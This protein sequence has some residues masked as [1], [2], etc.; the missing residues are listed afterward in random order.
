MAISG[1]ERFPSDNVPLMEALNKLRTTRTREDMTAHIEDVA[2][3][4]TPLV[5]AVLRAYFSP[6]WAKSVWNPS[7]K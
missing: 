1:D 5:G 2:G 7:K 6:K 4:Q 3:E